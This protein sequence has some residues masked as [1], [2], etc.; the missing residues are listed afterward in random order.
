M[1]IYLILKQKQKQEKNTNNERQNKVKFVVSP[2][3]KLASIFTD[4]FEND[5]Q[6][7]KTKITIITLMCYSKLIKLI[8]FIVCES[9]QSTT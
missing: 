3:L 5:L 1:S 4:L 2:L 9:Y 7:V 8:H 6:N